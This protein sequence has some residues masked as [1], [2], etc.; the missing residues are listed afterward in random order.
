MCVVSLFE[1][2]GSASPESVA[3]KL[4]ELPCLLFHASETCTASSN[5]GKDGISFSAVYLK[6]AFRIRGIDDSRK[7]R[8]RVHSIVYNALARSFRHHTAPVD[9]LLFEDLVVFIVRGMKNKE[10]GV[11]LAAG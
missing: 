4:S 3:I 8:P 10:R 11:R 2:T 7:I 6:V 9:T 5:D 1:V